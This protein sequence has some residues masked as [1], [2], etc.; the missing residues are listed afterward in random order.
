MKNGI[1]AE[2]QR[3]LN[4]TREEIAFDKS[5]HSPKRIRQMVNRAPAIISFYDAISSGQGM[6]AEIKDRSPSQGTMLHKNV[7]DIRPHY[8]LIL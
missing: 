7:E 5:R 6:I 3:I 8:K 1:S 2:L 4:D